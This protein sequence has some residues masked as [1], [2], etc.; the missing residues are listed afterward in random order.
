MR[1]HTYFLRPLHFLFRCLLLCFL[2]LAG[3]PVGLYARNEGRALIDSIVRELPRLPEDTTK[4]IVLNKLGSLCSAVDPDEGIR[5]G[6]LANTLSS[7]LGWSRGIATS[8]NVLGK[9]YVYKSDYSRALEYWKKA[10]PVFEALNDKQGLLAIIGN[11]GAVYEY[12]GNYTAALENFFIAL[13]YAEELGDKHSIALNLGNIGS[14]YEYLKDYNKALEYDLK[15]LAICKELGEQHSLAVY[16]GN[17]GNIYI[18]QHK[19]DQA[20][21]YQLEALKYDELTQNGEGIARD[22]ANIGSLYVNMKDYKM[23]L[24]Y[25]FRQLKVS[26]EI[27]F[28]VT[29]SKAHGF[30]GEALIMIAADVAAGKMQDGL[31]AAL[32]AEHIPASKTGLLRTAIDHLNKSIAINLEIT[33]LNELFHNYYSLA[34][35]QIMLGDY[36]EATESQRQYMLIKDSVFSADNKIAITNLET[37]REIELKN[38]QI[39]IHNKQIELDKLE[40]AKKRNERAFFIAGILLLCTVVVIVFRNLRLRSAKELSENKLN[41]FQARMNPHFIFNSLNSIQSLMLSNETIPS[42]RYLSEFSKLMRQILDNSARSRVML[43]AEIEMLGSYIKLEQLR[44]DNFIYVINIAD[45]ISVDGLYVPGMII[46]PFVENSIVHGFQPEMTN[47]L[48]T[49][50]FERRDK[51]IIC[52]VDDNGIGRARSAELNKEKNKDR[53]SHGINIATSRLSLLN[54]KKR[55]LVNKVIY[56]D[57]MENGIATGTQVIIQIPIL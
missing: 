35:A 50:T 18:D 3:L 20:L 17:I 33:N 39:E 46:Q 19:Y 25:Y 12:Q 53:Q 41:A 14:T 40:V 11:Y 26:K 1:I 57:K 10:Q 42:I 9:C 51:Q 36:K 38:K 5:Y 22:M 16:M 7:R 49:I 29:E 23:A 15:A 13:K 44:Y 45:D 54:D 30:I 2:L 24:S 6:I 4:A 47:G 28:K 21:T 55:G 27:G 8:Y 56:I 34:E 48:L 37:K 43:R 52:I 32:A 31:P